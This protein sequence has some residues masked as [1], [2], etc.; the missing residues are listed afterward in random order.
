MDKNLATIIIG[1]VFIL[2]ILGMF[3]GWRARSRK[4]S[5]FALLEPAPS[6]IGDI[7]MTSNG[8]YVATT[9]YSQPLE[10]I[11]VRG[12]GFRSRVTATVAQAGIVLA[13]TGQEPVFIAQTMLRSVQRGTWTIDKAVESG[14]LVVISWLMG[15]REVDSYLR[16]DDDPH[17]FVSA[18][19]GLVEVQE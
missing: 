3:L 16:L 18:A 7:L 14:G 19:D 13:L 8:L 1:A 12:L 5:D 15:D 6:E 4:Q 2:A 9:L 11:T 10:R 17:E